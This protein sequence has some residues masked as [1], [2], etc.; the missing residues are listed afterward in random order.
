MVIAVV[1]R[2]RAQEG[3]ADD[4]AS[5]LVPYADTV[6]AEPGCVAFHVNRGIDDNHTFYLYEV[7]EDQDALDRHV[8]SEHY[9]AVAAGRIRPLLAERDVTFLQP[10]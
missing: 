2:Y 8:G 6:R 7:Y 9:I 4:V 3:R 10:I 5:E 1:A